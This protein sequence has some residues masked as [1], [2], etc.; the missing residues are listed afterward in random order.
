MVPTGDI[1]FIYAVDTFYTRKFLPQFLS[2]GASSPDPLL[3]PSCYAIHLL[4]WHEE[5]LGLVGRVFRRLCRAGGSWIWFIDH[6]GCYIAVDPAFDVDEI[7]HLLH[8]D[9]H[10]HQKL[11]ELTADVLFESVTLPSP[12]FLYLPVGVARERQCIRSTSAER[13]RVDSIDWDSLHRW[14][15]QNFS[16][17]FQCRP[18]VAICDITPLAFFPV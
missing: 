13:V 11:R 8:A 16:R 15:F 18:D 2:S 9:A 17:E 1:V 12:H 3:L 4:V 10:S 14:I 6:G 7:E 5:E